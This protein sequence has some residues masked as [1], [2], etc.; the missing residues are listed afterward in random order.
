MLGLLMPS[1]LDGLTI[2]GHLDRRVYRRFCRD[3]WPKRYLGRIVIESV[4]SLR[5]TDLRRA[6]GQIVAHGAS[7]LALC[8]QH[9]PVWTETA[10]LLH[11]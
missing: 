8:G 7:S 10:S 4:R 9:Q 11:R 5:L 2:W 6:F 1:V 3:G